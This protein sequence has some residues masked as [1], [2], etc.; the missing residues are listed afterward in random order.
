LIVLGDPRLR[1]RAYG[2]TFLASLPAMPVIDDLS[3][4]LAF[5]T[6]LAGDVAVPVAAAV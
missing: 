5:A 2:A 3:E 1:T 6:S 4:A